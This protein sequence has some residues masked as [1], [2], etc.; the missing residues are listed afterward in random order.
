MKMEKEPEQGSS[1]SE[2][3]GGIFETDLEEAIRASLEDLRDIS[4]NEVP[5][6]DPL[7]AWECT[8]CTF[9]NSGGRYCEMCG[10]SSY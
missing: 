1:D 9:F 5:L 10:S 3:D 2:D 8:L 6:A 7:Q 4:T